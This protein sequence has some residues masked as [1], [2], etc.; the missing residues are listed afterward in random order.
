TQTGAY[1]RTDEVAAAFAPLDTTGPVHGGVTI[2]G[3]NG[4]TAVNGTTVYFNAQGAN[5]GS[6][7]VSDPIT[8]AESGIQ[9]D[10]FPAVAGL[11]GGATVTVPTYQST[12]HWTAAST[13]QGA[14]AAGLATNTFTRQAGTLSN[15]ACSGYGATTTPTIVGGNDNASPFATGC[16]LYTETGTDNVSNSAAIS[17]TV[18]VDQVFPTATPT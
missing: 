8:D 3:S 6:F 5:S 16:Y 2:S 14:A 1:N 12:Y 17:T 11:A 13:T 9:Q 18:K 10:L 4:F 15:N 7:T